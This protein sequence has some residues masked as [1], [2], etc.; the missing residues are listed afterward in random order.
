MINR[1]LI[2][3]ITGAA[4]RYMIDY[5]RDKH[6][7]VEIYGTTRRRALRLGQFPPD[8]DV[9]L[10]EVDLLDFGSI[11]NALGRSRPD[12]IFH[13]AANSDKGFDI[14]SAI[15]HN[16]AVGTVNL[17]EA[18]RQG[19]G[20]IWSNG[21]YDDPIIVN[22]SSS[23]VYGDVG[24]ADVPISETCPFRPMSPYAISKVAQDH[25]G[26]LYHKA[27]GMKVVNTRAFSYVN[28][29][30]HG[31]FT[32]HFAYQIAMIER[33]R[34]KVLKHGNLDSVRCF[35]DAKDI[36][37]AYWL[38]ATKCDYGEAY[39]IGGT[40]VMSVGEVLT[41]MDGLTCCVIKREQDPSL[42]RPADVTMQI[43]DCSKFITQTGWKPTFDVD[44]VLTELL[45]YW[46][47][48]VA[49]NDYYQNPV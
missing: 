40:C 33:S 6:P 9:C 14:P 43:P 39:N 13:F 10:H 25:L 49:K 48:R 4:G 5:L 19:M 16:N 23:E 34:L 46:R 7:E 45:E 30:H 47:N 2:T 32:S 20:T 24:P 36:M 18:I 31:I 38:A 35:V 29:R 27:Y 28:L 22:V 15:V 12:V 37:E 26:M 17:F 44:K 3:G 8:G 11:L 42:M 21:P 41:R 1:V